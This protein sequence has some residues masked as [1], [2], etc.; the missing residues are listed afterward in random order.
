MKRI[1][2][3]EIPKPVRIAIFVT[4]IAV[5]LLWFSGYFGF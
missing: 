3:I 2:G 4:F 1:L 5:T